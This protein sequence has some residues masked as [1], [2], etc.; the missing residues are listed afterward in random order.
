M[1]LRQVEPKGAVTTVPYV[2]SL[3]Y[4]TTVPYNP[5]PTRCRTAALLNGAYAEYNGGLLVAEGAGLISADEREARTIVF[6]EGD[7]AVTLE[8]EDLTDLSGLGTA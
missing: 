7:N 3:P 2:T 4:F 1:H 6:A 5:V 8:D